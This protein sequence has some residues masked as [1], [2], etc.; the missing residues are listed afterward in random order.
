MFVWTVVNYNLN[1]LLRALNLKQ[2]LPMVYRKNKQTTDPCTT[3]ICCDMETDSLAS[4]SMVRRETNKAITSEVRQHPSYNPDHSSKKNDLLRSRTLSGFGMIS[5]S[6][7][8]PVRLA[9][10]KQR[11]DLSNPWRDSFPDLNTR[12]SSIPVSWHSDTVLTQ[13]RRWSWLWLWR[14]DNTNAGRVGS[15][16]SKLETWVV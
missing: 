15:R 1:G 13:L 16:W 14:G 3:H 11:R 7:G 2:T 5:F 12:Y 6:S 8:E 4:S 10:P 9:F